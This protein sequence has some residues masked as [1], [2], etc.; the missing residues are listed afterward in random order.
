MLLRSQVWWYFLK[1]FKAKNQRTILTL[2]NPT[3]S[4]PVPNRA[5]RRNTEETLQTVHDI[6]FLHH[7]SA[8][9]LA[10]VL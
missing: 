8:L 5:I 9:A 6:L 4:I 7:Y 1:E 3:T 10:F 2:S